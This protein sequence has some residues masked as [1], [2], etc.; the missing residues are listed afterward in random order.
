MQ[1]CESLCTA[2]H[3]REVPLKVLHEAQQERPIVPLSFDVYHVQALG[4]LVVCGD[5]AGIEMSAC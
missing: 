2:H 5:F 4:R 3:S 1:G